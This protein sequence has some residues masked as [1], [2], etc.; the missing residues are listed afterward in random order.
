MQTAP[1]KHRQLFFLNGSPHA[2]AV[3]STA[4]L[5]CI[6]VIKSRPEPEALPQLIQTCL[7][8]PAASLC[9]ANR[10]RLFLIK[11]FLILT[12]YRQIMDVCSRGERRRYLLIVGNCS[13]KECIK[14]LKRPCCLSV[15]RNLR[16]QLCVVP[17]GS[18]RCFVESV[19]TL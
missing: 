9:E 13:P 1:W 14:S 12:F 4:K 16:A 11:L 5:R 8:A 3:T 17:H 2:F 15:P 10:Q 6:A 7:F 18:I 19:L